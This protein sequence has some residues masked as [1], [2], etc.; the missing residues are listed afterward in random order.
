MKEVFDLQ[1]IGPRARAGGGRGLAQRG[2]KTIVSEAISLALAIYTGKHSEHRYETLFR[3]ETAGAL[4]PDNA[5]KYVQMLRKARE[6]GSFGQVIFIAQQPDVW[7]QA[8]AV[9]W[10]QDGRVEVRK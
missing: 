2:E 7:Q 8:D 1:V 6:V 4:D 9:L 3:D 5:H 10:C